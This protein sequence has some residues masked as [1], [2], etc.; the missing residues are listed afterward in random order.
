L[1]TK[2]GQAQMT[3]QDAPSASK[4][5]VKRVDLDPLLARNRRDQLANRF[6]RQSSGD[7]K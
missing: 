3:K 1:T 6:E 7:S 4:V 5:A 2:A